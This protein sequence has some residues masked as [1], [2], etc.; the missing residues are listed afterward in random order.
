MS[1]VK[2]QI[3]EAGYLYTRVQPR[4]RWQARHVTRKRLVG[5]ISELLR[6]HS[7]RGRLIRRWWQS[8]LN[9]IGSR[10]YTSQHS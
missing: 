9:R 2:F 8:Y 4:S 1:K 7:A 6:E 3:S 5:H 10:R